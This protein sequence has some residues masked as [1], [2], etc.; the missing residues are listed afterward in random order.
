MA[1]TKQ[2]ILDKLATIAAPD[3]RPLPVAATLSD[4]V[5]SDGKVFFSI[6]V[7]AAAVQAWEPIR[8]RAEDAVRAM[9]G[10]QSA[11][12]ALT[13]ERRPGTPSAP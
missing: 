2:D 7:D 6:T 3:G 9:S 5:A 8:K 1:P 12:I 13:A 10:V 4:I 11:M